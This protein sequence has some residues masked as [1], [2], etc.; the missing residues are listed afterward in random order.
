MAKI[1]AK[2]IQNNLSV[3]EKQILNAWLA[4]SSL[5]RSFYNKIID[6]ERIKQKMHSYSGINWEEDYHTF[7]RRKNRQR[8]IVKIRKLAKYAAILILPLALAVYALFLGVKPSQQEMLNE[9]LELHQPGSS[10]ARLIDEMGRIYEL[11]DTSNSFVLDSTFNIQNTGQSIRY[12]SPV[13]LSMTMLPKLEEFHT[14][15]VPTGGEYLLE[16]IDGTKVWLNS[17]SEIKYPKH[18]IA[19]HRTIELKGEAYF[20]VAPDPE[21]PFVVKTEAGVVKVLGTKFNIKAYEGEFNY[22]TL[23]EGSVSLQHRYDDRSLIVLEPGD[24]AEIIDVNHR[25]RVKKV[26]PYDYT[27][28]KDNRLVFNSQRLE[29]ILTIISRWYGAD[30]EIDDELKDITLTADIRKYS[31]LS[32]ILAYIN[33]STQAKLQFELVDNTM[34]I[35]QAK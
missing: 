28:W 18:M 2:S 26:K 25:I 23:V 15:I 12:S 11:Q 1:L 34:H 7:I 21:K 10:K 32:T 20:E 8:R 33:T 19:D 27:A 31:Q 4:E 3:Q 35:K 30:F 16:M 29:D 17:E 9:F 6:E 14:I 13:K 22:T 5:H 24:Q